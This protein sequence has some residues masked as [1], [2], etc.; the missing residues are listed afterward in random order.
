MTDDTIAFGPFVLDRTLRQVRRGGEP[1]A[2]GDR[3]F[4]LLNTLLEARGRPVSKQ[5]LIEQAWPGLVI[6]EGNLT[7]QISTLR[8]HL[9]E[10]GTALIVTV[11]R[12]GYRFV[13]PAAASD[14]RSDA[15]HRGPPIIAVIAFANL[16]SAAEDG[17]FADGVVDDIITALSRFR[18][19]AVLSRGTSLML[20]E[21]G[22]GAGAAAAELGARY[23]LEGSIRRMGDRLRVTAQLSDARSAAQLWAERYDGAAAEIFSFQDHI[24]GSVAGRIEPTIRLAEIERVR[25]KPPQSL[26]AYDWFLKA[27]PLVHAPG[28]EGHPEALALLERAAKLDPEFALPPAYAAWIYEKR[29]SLRAPPLGP[30]DRESCIELARL[31]M[32]LGRHDPLVRAICGY[33]LYRVGDEPSAL[34]AV[35]QAAKENPYNVSILQLAGMSVGVIHGAVDEGYDY[36]ARAYDLSPGAPEAYQFLQAM[37]SMELMRGNAEA[38]IEL[39]LRVLATFNDWL[40]TYI[41]LTAAYATLDR[42]DEARAMLRRLRELNPKL[43]IKLLEGNLASEHAFADVAMVGLRKAGLPES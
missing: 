19:F 35:R 38:A 14:P 31:A 33:L 6:E 29:F 20:R 26:D 7:V 34:Q 21:K 16:G 41:L 40:F 32:T 4:V 17:Y 24:T 9:G 27:M 12:V 39:G 23:V 10:D 8:R 36:C 25:R 13:P 18:N 1:L 15:N 5:T 3:G 28:A 43:T 30:H 22:T 37:A 42:M 11:P 2:I